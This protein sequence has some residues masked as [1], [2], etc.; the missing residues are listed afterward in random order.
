MKKAIITFCW[1]VITC[2]GVAQTTN[3]NRIDN[4]EELNIYGSNNKTIIIGTAVININNSAKPATLLKSISQERQKD[5]TYLTTIL[6][7]SGTKGM[8]IFGLD[9][10]IAF[11]KSFLT[12]GVI[13][14]AAMGVAKSIADNNKTY[15]I[16]ADQIN[17]GEISFYVTSNDRVV[18]KIYGIDGMVK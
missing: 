6:I 16:S 7:V 9:V 5:G 8:P 17:G 18:P 2:V 12:V 11:D 1:L 3:N 14:G 10:V 15:H 13:S 4:V